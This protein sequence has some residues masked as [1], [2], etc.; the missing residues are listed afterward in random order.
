MLT[1]DTHFEVRTGCAAGFDAHLH[2]LAHAVAIDR[3]EGILGQDAAFHILQQEV[4]FGVIPADAKG[5][6]RQVVGAEAEELRR[7][8]I[9]PLLG[10][11]RDFDLV[12]NL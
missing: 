7:F 12:P 5:H 2:Q 1:A 9:S 10:G 11:A 6:L 8:A 3:L 4:T